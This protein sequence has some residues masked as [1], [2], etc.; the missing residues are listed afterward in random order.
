[1]PFKTFIDS[2]IINQF[3]QYVALGEEIPEPKIGSTVPEIRETLV[4]Q[5]K[6]GNNDLYALLLSAPGEDIEE[7]NE[8]LNVE[9]RISL[10]SNP[11]ATSS[12]KISYRNRDGSSDKIKEFAER[13]CDSCEGVM[14]DKTGFPAVTAHIYLGYNHPEYKEMVIKFLGSGVMFYKVN[15]PYEFKKEY[16]NNVY[17]VA[18]EIILSTLGLTIEDVLERIS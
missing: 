3:L 16:G 6:A 17:T 11:R 1:M 18:N 15:L 8:A 10:G 12:F 4:N 7:L 2:K 13:I 9:A 5:I 14:F